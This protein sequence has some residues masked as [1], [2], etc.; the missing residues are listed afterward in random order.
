MKLE[1]SGGLDYFVGREGQHVFPAL[2]THGS[3]DGGYCRVDNVDREHL[4]GVIWSSILC[5]HSKRPVP[6]QN[7]VVELIVL[8]RRA[9]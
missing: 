3:V 7:D 6:G 4:R 9:F 1:R 5:N 8:E 2:L